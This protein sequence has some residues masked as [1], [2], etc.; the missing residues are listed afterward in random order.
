[1]ERM[2]L[3]LAR[4]G[5]SH[6]RR[7]TVENT[8]VQRVPAWA[9]VTLGLA[10][11]AAVVAALA[12]GGRAANAAP[13]ADLRLTKTIEPMVVTVGQNQTFTIIVKN[14]SAAKATNVKMTDPLPTNVRFIRAS[15]SLHRPG[16]CGETNRTVECQHGT[17]EGGEK[18]TIKIFV[19]VV[20]AGRY[21]NRAFVSQKSR[22]LDPSDNDDTANARAERR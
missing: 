20:K 2:M 10:L 14:Q 9:M 21:T 5:T 13:G 1:M 19:E 4:K 6:G 12:F 7:R 8:S 3:M 15:T 18:V 17:L 22:E 11:A 16:S